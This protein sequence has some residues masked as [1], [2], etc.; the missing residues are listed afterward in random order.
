MYLQQEENRITRTDYHFALVASEIRRSFVKK[1]VKVRIKDFL[2]KFTTKNKKTETLE[3]Y[4]AR[5]K[6]AWMAFAGVKET[7]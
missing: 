4:T 6:N 5:S 1:G 3:E 2:L 7:K